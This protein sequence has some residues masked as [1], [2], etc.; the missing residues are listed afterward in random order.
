MQHTTNPHGQG[1]EK[2]TSI[3]TAGGENRQD[4]QKRHR[5]EATLWIIGLL[6]LIAS[7]SPDGSPGLFYVARSVLVKCFLA[8]PRTRISLSSLGREAFN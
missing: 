8:R 7:G 4:A 2:P 6:A 3:T 5:L 1:I